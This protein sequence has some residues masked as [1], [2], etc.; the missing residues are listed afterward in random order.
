MM[1]WMLGTG[2][3]VSLLIV[4]VLLVR[5]PFARMFGAKAVYALWVLPFLR[6]VMPEVT[7]P[8]FLP[9]IFQSSSLET[10]L[11]NE[12]SLIHI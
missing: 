1:N 10:A 4:L 12:L 3:A 5:R 8:R 2:V 6:L 11:P 7:L 9:R